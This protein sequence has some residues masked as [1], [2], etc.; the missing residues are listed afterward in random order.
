[1]RW[2]LALL[3]LPLAATMVKRETPPPAFDADLFSKDRQIYSVHG[4]FLYWTAVEGCLDYALKMKHNAWSTSTASYS[5]G[6]FENAKYDIDPGFRIGLIYFRAPHFWEVRWHYTHLQN[7]GHNSVGKPH[8]DQN[9]LT[10]TWPQVFLAPMAGAWS[11]IRLNYNVFDWLVD[12]VFFPNPHMRLRVLGGGILSWL[13]QDWK[14]RYYDS[15]NNST[16]IRNKWQYVAGG[17]KTGT[18]VDWYWSHDFYVT[19]TAAFAVLIGSYG[20]E[21]KITTTASPAAGDNPTIPVR[22]AKYND[23]RPSFL[24]QLAFGPSWQKSYHKTR[25][26]AFTGFE[27]NIWSNLQEIFRSSSGTP[28]QEKETYINYSLLSLFGLTTRVSADF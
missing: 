14:V 20:N 3:I 11:H 12:R 6:R 8:P 18:I 26:E 1:M 5:Q 23:T 9:Y 28:T 17:L 27:A 15:I 13:N 4:E 24:A 16:T 19:G 2:I 22:D 7:E 25:I 21:G 10:G